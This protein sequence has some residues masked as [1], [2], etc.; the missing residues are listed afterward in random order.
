MY[1]HVWQFLSIHVIMIHVFLLEGNTLLAQCFFP[2]MP[3][4]VDFII[5]SLMEQVVSEFSVSTSPYPDLS[6]AHSCQSWLLF[7]LVKCLEDSMFLIP[8]VH[9]QPSVGCWPLLEALFF[10]WLPEP[11]IL[12]GIPPS[13]H[14]FSGWSLLCVLLIFQTR[15]YGEELLFWCLYYPCVLTYDPK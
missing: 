6:P 5:V 1:Y 8:V 13:S 12:P 9:F 14:P 15:Y 2:A 10:T 4:W 7:S 3:W 11:Y